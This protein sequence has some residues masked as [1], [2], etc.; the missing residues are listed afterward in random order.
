MNSKETLSILR[1]L[2]VQFQLPIIE[3]RKICRSSF[4]FVA[5]EM[6][7]L[8]KID[9]NRSI[10]FPYLL[11]FDLLKKKEKRLENLRLK[12][13]QRDSAARGSGD[14]GVQGTVE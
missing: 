12:R 14:T 2:A 6:Y 3:I 9:E 10:A 5:D 7:K 8:D 1:E 13:K 11:R 4:E